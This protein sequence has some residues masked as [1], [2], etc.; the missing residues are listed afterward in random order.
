MEVS[1][2]FIGVMETHTLV[3]IYLVML[4]HTSMLSSHQLSVLWLDTIE[5]EDVIG[6][7]YGKY[8]DQVESD[9]KG[10]EDEQEYE[11]YPPIHTNLIT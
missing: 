4:K 10:L 3:S 6:I 8:E 2:N 1:R 9:K 7:N 11:D 5:V